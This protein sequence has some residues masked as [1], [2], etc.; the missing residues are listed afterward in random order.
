MPSTAP[1]Q[2][3]LIQFLQPHVGFEERVHRHDVAELLVPVHGLYRALD[4]AGVEQRA[5]VGQAVIHPPGAAH[6]PMVRR[7]ADLTAYLLQWAGGRSLPVSGSRVLDDAAGHLLHACA[8]LWQ[9]RRAERGEALE[10]LLPVLVDEVTGLLA[11]GA[12]V[13]LHPIDRVRAFIDDNIGYH[14][15]LAELAHAA[16]MSVPNMQRHFR[17]RFGVSP[18]RYLQQ[19]RLQRATTLL[20]ETRLPI[21]EVARRTG[22]R[23]PSW[24]SRWFKNATGRTPRDIRR[25]GEQDADGRS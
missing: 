23:N 12:R 3:E 14:W 2:V 8:W 1:A 9:L 19:C 13:D 25:V 20:R 6:V 17:C 18:I 4:S 7:E 11:A 10:H 24:F 15:G 22:L 5:R 21:A 16:G